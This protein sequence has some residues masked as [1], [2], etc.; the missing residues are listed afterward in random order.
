MDQNGH[1]LNSRTKAGGLVLAGQLTLGISRSGNGD[2]ITILPA[3]TNSVILGQTSEL[4]QKQ[5]VGDV[6]MSMPVTK[7]T[8]TFAAIA[9]L[10]N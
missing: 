4:L 2:L 8:A 1:V 6:Q 5:V 3:T 10:V 7:E 9:V